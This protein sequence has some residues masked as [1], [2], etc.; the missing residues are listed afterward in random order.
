MAEAAEAVLAIPDKRAAQ[1]ARIT[2]RQL[3]YWEQRDLIVPP[4]NASSAHAT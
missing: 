2:M 1:L 3:R 4:S